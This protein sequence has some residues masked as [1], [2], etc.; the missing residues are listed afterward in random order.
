[1]LWIVVTA[2]VSS[3]ASAAKD[4]SK[5]LDKIIAKHSIARD[6]LGLAV[7]DLQKNDLIYGLNE[8]REM[9]PASI[10]K[11]VT[12]AAVLQKIGAGTK[13]QTGLYS[14]APIQDGTLKGDLV[15]KGG[16]DS[17]FVSESMWFLV[18]ELMR[19]GIKKVEGNILVDDTDFD[20]VRTDP[21]RDPERVDRAYDAP[22]GAMS[23]NWNSISIFIRPGEVG[24]PPKVYLDPIDNGFTVVNRAKTSS[25]GGNNLEVSRDGDKITVK[26][27]IGVNN[28]EVPVYKNID[29]PV[30]WSGR[31]L[32]FFLSQRGIQ[33]S[34]KVMAGRRTPEMKL[35][36]K[37]DS[38]PINQAVADMMKFS[39]NYVAEMLTKNLAAN[40]S[41]KDHATLEGGMKVIRSFLNELG[42]SDGRFTLVN[43]S[44][45]S[46]RNKMKAID[47]GKV[48]V[49]SYKHFPTFAEYLTAL[50]MA[51]V[52][53]T[54]KNRMKG[55][56]GQSW[57]R[58]KTG[59]LTG[60]VGL[61]GFAG[62]KDGSVRAF[63]FIFN[64]SGEQGD[65]GRRL[66]DALATELVQ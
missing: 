14:R 8:N 18:N 66:F 30:E 38:K 23:F 12:A 46:R 17:G 47:L 5:D 28:S 11:V 48:L 63:V 13:L 57:V 6:K 21:S 2:F 53:G 1:M 25:S 35:L 4:L 7:F 61:A 59:L 44:G 31:N 43:P 15:L 29:D 34:G 50:P 26:G 56:N 27:T 20:S 22:V 16:G 54:L 9:T 42:I 60:V 33:V 10:T 64:G 41:P 39:N 24:Q 3:G 37:A 19:T 55:G 40:Q 45:L 52:D 36:A 65:S 51:G 32:V 58:A 62:R 49:S